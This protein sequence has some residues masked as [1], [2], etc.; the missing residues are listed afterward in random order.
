RE[1]DWEKL[2]KELDASTKN[3]GAK[4]GN[5]GWWIGLLLL[6]M[7]SGI[8]W[9]WKYWEQKKQDVIAN[10][11]GASP[12]LALSGAG[13]LREDTLG[14]T[15]KADLK[16]MDGSVRNGLRPLKSPQGIAQTESTQLLKQET[17]MMQHEVSA[18]SARI[19]EPGQGKRS[20][21]IPVGSRQPTNPHL[22]D[23]LNGGNEKAQL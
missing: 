9:G 23:F 16:S 2:R 13:K 5:K 10:A 1:E 17:A 8:G 6:T 14:I 18:F 22:S 19:S 3:N 15:D 12:S 20:I 4:P 7:I 11:T 21:I